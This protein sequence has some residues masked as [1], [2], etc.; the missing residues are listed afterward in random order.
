MTVNG[1]RPVLSDGNVLKLGFGDS[2]AVLEI[3][4]YI[5]YTSV[6]LFIKIKKS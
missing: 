4:W 2:C 1:L 6:R 3:L 5:N